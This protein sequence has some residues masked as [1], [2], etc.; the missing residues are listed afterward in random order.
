MARPAPRELP[1]VPA[2]SPG[3]SQRRYSPEPVSGVTLA[4]ALYAKQPTC[5]AGAGGGS[6][7]SR[8]QAAS[9]PRANSRVPTCENMLLVP[10][11]R[12]Q[13]EP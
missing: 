5:E 2:G 10:K 11:I 13:A 9:E 8:A 1:R 4:E 7:G 3:G 6:T 12:R